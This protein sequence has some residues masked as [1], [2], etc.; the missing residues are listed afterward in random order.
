MND[1]FFYPYS[2]DL[3]LG[4]NIQPEE[5]ERQLEQLKNIPKNKKILM[6]AV[7]AVK[8]SILQKIIAHIQKL[9][10]LDRTIWLLQ[11]SHNYSENTLIPIKQRL[12]KID[13]DILFLNLQVNVCNT[14]RLNTQWNYNTKKFL[15]LTGKPDRQ[16]RIKLLH[17]FYKAGLL[18]YCDWSLFVGETVYQR[19]RDLLP[20]LSDIEF[21]NFVTSHNRNLDQL[22]IF[23]H[24]S[25]SISSEGY[26]F[27]GELY[28]KSSFRVVSETMM[29]S[30][31]VITEKT[32][33]TIANRMPFMI[34]GYPNN[35]SY[36]KKI[37]Y[38]TF[39]NYLPE[40]DYDSVMDIDSRL[41][42]VVKNTKFWIDNIHL[43][44][45]QIQ[46]DVEY[47]YNLFIKHTEI[48]IQLAKKLLD[49]IGE[50]DRSIYAL[51]P[52]AIEQSIWVSFYYNVK[53][54]SWPDCFLEDNFE[55]LPPL[56][57]KECIE[58]FGYQTKN[59][60]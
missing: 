55:K 7:E 39:E 47:N 33:I 56:I 19:T 26:P 12:Y 3:F 36:L 43:Q 28:S 5:L 40:S 24:T 2:F 29:L 25:N 21:D 34:I 1:P 9:E 53:D 6:W 50:N 18:T 17:K 42:L 13:F 58:Q 45:N 48:N 54:P 23:H 14:S 57:K 51:V 27:D 60:N 8:E 46:N 41:D 49:E 22:K 16:N 11:P 31:P 44:K 15:F 30:T 35:L 38:C 32:W 59:S 37:G 10:L 4:M 52:A 20:E